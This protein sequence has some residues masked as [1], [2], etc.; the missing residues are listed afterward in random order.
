MSSL[1]ACD[2]LAV[3]F[4][5]RS[6]LEGLSFGL[7]GGEALLIRGPSGCGKSTLLRTLVGLIPAVSGEITLLGTPLDQ[8]ERPAMRRTCVYFHQHPGFHAGSVGAALARPLQ[9]GVAG[10][11]RFD[12]ERAAGLLAQLGLDNGVLDQPVEQ[13]SG[14]QAQRVALARALLLEPRVLLLD[15]PT[16]ALDEASGD[17]V[18]EQLE[19]FM[20]GGGGVLVAAHDGSIAAE[21]GASRLDLNDYA[22]AEG[23]RTE[24]AA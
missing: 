16:S 12:R 8:H 21:L 4:S 15:E 14:G 5:D 3:G 17:R 23:A 13:L 22:V 6:L 10:E 24:A 18:I 19:A 7:S 1:L 9:F 20:A 11:Q 2:D